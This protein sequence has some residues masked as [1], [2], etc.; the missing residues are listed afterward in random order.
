MPGNNSKRQKQKLDKTLNKLMRTIHKALSLFLISAVSLACADQD[1]RV[2][3]EKE[4]D[5]ILRGMSLDN[6]IGQMILLESQMVAYKNK[7]YEYKNL[8]ALEEKELSELI[9]K[10]GLEDKANAARLIQL[11]E[12]GS[13][14]ALYAYYTLSMALNSDQCFHLDQDRM[15]SVFGD[16]HVGALLNMLGTEGD[17]LDVWN[18]SISVLEKASKD[19]NG[20]L[21][22]IYGLDQV[23]GPTYIFGGTM[24]PQQIGLAATFN[25]ELIKELGEMNAY[26]TRAGGVR[27]I[28]GPSMDLAVKPSWPRVYESW[29]EDPYLTSVMATSYMQG[30]QGP[31]PDNIDSYHAVTCV[32]HYLGYGSPDNGL[33]RTTTTISE[34]D[35]REKHFEPFKR[36]ALAGALSFMTNSSIV[37]GEPGVCNRRFLTEW[38][39]EDLNWDGVIVTDWGDVTD[40]YSLYNVAPDMKSAIAMV[41][42][43]G[44][45]MLMVP[46]SLEFGPALNELVQEGVVKM[47]RI[48]DAVRRILRLKYRAGLFKEDQPADYSLFGSLEFSRKA[49]HAAVE[50]QVLLKNED[51]VLPITGPARILVCGPNA[52]TMRGLNGGWTY[53]WQGSKV[54]Q[55]YKPYNTILKAL[56]NKFGDRN[57]IF[58]PGVE[59]DMDGD[60]QDEKTPQIGKAVAAAK[61][62]DYI[63]AC[64]GENSYAETR[65]NI[66]DLN[67]SQNQKNLVKELCKTGKPVI[68]VINSGR[69]RLIAD[70]VPSV[71]A[72]VNIMLP[73]NY[74][75]DAFA[76]LL[77]GDQNFSGK[78]PMTYPAHP[79]AF[80]TYNFKVLEDRSTTPG[81][82]NYENHANVQWWFGDGLSYTTFT[83]SN[84]TADKLTFNPEDTINFSV[85]VTNTGKIGGKE[86]VLLFSSDNNASGILPDNRRLRAFK[87]ITLVPGEK[88]TVTLS[89]PAKDL[90]FVG[91]DGKWH[92][93]EG[94]FT[95]M[96]GGQFLK[97]N[98]KSSIVF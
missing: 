69:P 65:G 30:V 78:M 45:D 55:Y 74:G 40:L 9:R 87:K 62:A 68:L 13:N 54:E 5:S 66:L 84:L 26:E 81:I 89:V 21:P 98:C 50:S 29:G 8:M 39:K 1:S 36:A 22:M 76:A 38:L 41:V 27:W 56:Q 43:A 83:Y 64:V 92:L 72:I 7:D 85:D 58:E 61:K 19:F 10:A 91:T 52:N 42:N 71:K 97:I 31:D 25:P 33:D 46:S 48:D 73:G 82:Y 18:S 51:N 53:S 17:S 2:V 79:N 28:Y 14:S 49:F 12:S 60:W 44:V 4:I 63:I 34:P 15:K 95:F 77:S 94:G 70:L 16:Y 57:I 59:Y 23:H 6:K 3:M 80:T 88:Q 11:K 37:N 67:L 90:A 75:G 32:K 47:D 93:E 24:F 20:G 96:S 86:T 35:L